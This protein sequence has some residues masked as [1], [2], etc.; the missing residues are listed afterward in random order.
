LIGSECFECGVGNYNSRKS[1][2]D[3]Y[4]EFLTNEPIDI[5]VTELELFSSG[6]KYFTGKWALETVN[7]I[8]DDAF[9]KTFGKTDRY[10]VFIIERM[11]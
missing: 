1:L 11:F 7:M 2:E 5:E 9:N 10:K 8:S 6:K 4:L 3:G